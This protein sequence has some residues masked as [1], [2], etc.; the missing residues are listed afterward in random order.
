VRLRHGAPVTGIAF[1]GDGRRLASIADGEVRVWDAANGA[2]VR[3]LKERWGEAGAALTP[4]GASAVIGLRDGSVHL[5]RDVSG[6]GFGALLGEPEC[7]ALPALALRKLRCVA[8]SDDGALVAAAE[9]RRPDGDEAGPPGRI[10]RVGDGTEEAGFGFPG[11]ISAAFSPDGRW[12][13]T[14]QDDGEV[15]LWRIG[16]PDD[17]RFLGRVAPVKPGPAVALAWSPDGRVLYSGHASDI[18]IGW[19]VGRARK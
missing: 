9:W 7:I 6:T 2:L 14:G 10:V 4:D 19:D 15:H 18:V 11:T 1:S 8:I 3:S 16:A 13:A 17:W 12:I 5:A